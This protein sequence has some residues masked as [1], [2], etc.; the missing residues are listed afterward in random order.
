MTPRLDPRRI[1]RGAHLEVLAQITSRCGIVVGGVCV[2]GGSVGGSGAV[3]VGRRKKAMH[4]DT[5]VGVPSFLA[6]KSVHRGEGKTLGWVIAGFVLN[7]FV[8]GLGDDVI[9]RDGYG[10]SGGGVK[11]VKGSGVRVL[12]LHGRA[13]EPRGDAVGD[14]GAPAG[15]SHEG[16]R[17]REGMGVVGEVGGTR[18]VCAS[19]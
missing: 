18:E 19:G 14:G 4:D 12:F 7:G 11:M 15:A 9:E 16:E 6:S 2:D 1:G 8:Q 10:C 5:A 17:H 13:P 3:R